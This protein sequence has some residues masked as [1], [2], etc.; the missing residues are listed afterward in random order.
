DNPDA[1]VFLASAIIAVSSCAIVSLIFIP[2]IQYLRHAEHDDKNDKIRI[3]GIEQSGVSNSDSGNALPTFK[4][5]ANSTDAEEE[6]YGDRIITTKTKRQLVEEN[7]ALRRRIRVL[8]AGRLEEK[9]TDGTPSPDD[10]TR[11]EEAAK[12]KEEADQGNDEEKNA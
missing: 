2:K 7:A 8:A 1:S 12:H 3:T 4:T 9:T 5:S 10:S 6:N 11:I